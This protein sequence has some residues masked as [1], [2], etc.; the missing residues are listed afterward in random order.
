MLSKPSWLKIR[1]PTGAGIQTYA[2]VKNTIKNLELVTVC[3]EAK[4]PNISECWS[5]GTATFMVM[6]DTC[7]RGCKFCYVKTAR[8]GNTLDLLEP[9]KLA[10]DIKKY[11]LSYVV[12]TSVDRDDLN[13]QGA[14]HFAKCIK[15]KKEK[16]PSLIV[17]VLIP[18][19][20]ANTNCLDTIIKA[21][22]DVIAHNIET[23]KELQRKVRDVRANYEQSLSVLKY[24]KKVSPKTVTKSSI[25]IG[26]GETK[27]QV[28]TTMNDLLSVGVQ[29]LT[30]GQ[31]LQPSKMHLAVTQY[32]HPTTFEEYKVQGEKKGFL[33]VASGPFV[34]SSYRAGEYYLKNIIKKEKKNVG[35]TNTF[36]QTGEIK[37]SPDFA[38]EGKKNN[39]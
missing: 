17:E 1:P 6:G 34:R 3:E 8:T 23:V 31:Y 29:A 30:I 39:A 5:K 26:L 10:K 19:F 12:I 11:N 38:N 4:C 9:I 2:N 37:V 7:T 14:E 16:N 28:Y 25:M 33:Y 20:R 18:D 21:K 35:E 27:K 24:V 15:V 36:S 13:D 22:P 32:V